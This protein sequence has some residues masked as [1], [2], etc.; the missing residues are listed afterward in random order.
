MSVKMTKKLAV[1]KIESFDRE[2]LIKTI[3]PYVEDPVY[4]AKQE[5]IKDEVKMLR[6]RCSVCGH[7]WDEQ[8]MASSW[9]AYRCNAA[10]CPHCAASTKRTI[11]VDGYDAGL[12]SFFVERED[13]FVIVQFRVR[14]DFEYDRN[15]IFSWM[16]QTPTRE[17]KLQSMLFFFKEYGYLGYDSLTRKIQNPSIALSALIRDMTRKIHINESDLNTPSATYVANADAFMKEKE[18]KNAEKRANSKA[19]R[20]NE[21]RENYVPKDLAKTI[22]DKTCHNGVV[23]RQVSNYGNNYLWAVGC[24]KCNSISNVSVEGNVDKFVCP[25][26]HEEGT[27]VGW[28][29]YRNSQGSYI[30]YESTT[31]PENDLLI[32]FW[33][34]TINLEKDDSGKYFI[35]RTV[36]E[37][38]RIF[39]GKKIVCYAVNSNGTVFKVRSNSY[40]AMPY[41]RTKTI[42]SDEEIRIA[43]TNS[44]L[45]YSGLV[46]AYGL[47]DDRYKSFC[48]PSELRYLQTWYKKPNIE[49]ILKANL[50]KC[51]ESIV[52]NPDSIIAGG[53]NVCEVLDIPKCVLKISQKLNLSL[54]EI[55]LAKR[56]YDVNGSLTADEYKEISD[57]GLEVQTMI[58]IRERY[59]IQVEDIIRYIQ[60][61][62]DHQ[63]IEKREALNIWSDYLR[64]AV[65]IGINLSD[66]SRRFPSSMKKE[67]DVAMFA[68]R[69]I[70]EKLDREMFK[71]QA[72][73]NE[74]EL[75]YHFGDYLIVIP[76][77]PED[78]VLEATKQKNCLRSYVT[79]I[80]N[81]DTAVCFIRK[82]EE[83]D[84]T[85]VT[86]EVRN[87]RILQVKGYC[88]SNPRDKK[89][90][91]FIQHWMKAKG[92]VWAC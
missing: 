75:G 35:K 26:C 76:Q 38:A 77:S 41:Y 90:M 62:Y 79:R 69:E 22:E 10:T 14:Y 39:C 44:C 61:A 50:T 15:N 80:K 46:E 84:E 67:H 60:S 31:L 56:L 6:C 57:S 81:G 13:G 72:A 8:A 71:D 78:V 55:R 65:K 54:Y 82:K 16:E 85:F 91:E 42:Q 52:T 23:A 1:E 25:V 32:R 53:K 49:L 21:V 20:L 17:I 24:L 43:I 58:S 92:L 86:V 59:N 2:A 18:Q 3:E 74:K 83:P 36:T 37:R 88:N 64:M 29:A 30:T 34:V 66:K 47:G 73:E 5:Y 7:E 27:T 28:G 11:R 87:S 33:N 45:R 63:C 68:Y 4:I 9:S 19:T 40:E 89:L 12:S 70:A 51:L 48:D